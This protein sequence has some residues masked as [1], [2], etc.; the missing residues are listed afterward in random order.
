[1]RA[2]LAVSPGPVAAYGPSMATLSTPGP[3]GRGDVSVVSVTVAP[4]SRSGG[5][6]TPSCSHD[7]P[8][9][10]TPTTRLPARTGT[11]KVRSASAPVR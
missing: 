4:Y 9:N 8:T 7:L 5:C 3:S 1:M 10:D 6:S 2:R 11:R